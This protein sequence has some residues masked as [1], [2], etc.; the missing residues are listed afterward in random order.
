MTGL[1]TAE[2]NVMSPSEK[3]KKVRE[4]IDVGASPED[5]KKIGRGA[6]VESVDRATKAQSEF[7]YEGFFDYDLDAPIARKGK[8][9]GMPKELAEKES[10]QH[11]MS[12]SNPSLDKVREI[13]SDLQKA[14][15][16]TEIEEE[17]T[18]LAELNND[19]IQDVHVQAVA[20]GRATAE[21]AQDSLAGTPVQTADDIS[22]FE[23]FYAMNLTRAMA[24]TEAAEADQDQKLAELIQDDFT[25]DVAIAQRVA[26]YQGALSTSFLELA[27]GAILDVIPLVTQISMV[28]AINSVLGESV[29]SAGDLFRGQ[30]TKNIR[31]KL[32]EMPPD[33]RYLV[34][35]DIME[36]IQESSGFLSMADYQRQQV[37]LSLFNPEYGL[38][39]ESIDNAISILD[40]LSL[41]WTARALWTSTKVGFKPGS[42]LDTLNM[43]NPDAAAKAA[44]AGIKTDAGDVLQMTPEEIIETAVLPSPFGKDFYN[45][46]ADITKYLDEADDIVDNIEARTLSNPLALLPE[47]QDLASKVIRKQLQ[48]IN[49]NG[50]YDSNIAVKSTENSVQFT[51]NY[52]YRTAE[53]VVIPFGTRKEALD[54][55]LRQFP[56]AKGIKIF[57]VTKTKG[58]RPVPKNKFE[59]T[60]KGQYIYEVQGEKSAVDIQVGANKLF[61]NDGD[62]VRS[63]TMK[64]WFFDPA[65]RF[66]KWISQGYDQAGDWGKGI[67]TE[68]ATLAK[69]FESLKTAKQRH[70]VRML[71]DYAKD[72]SWDTLRLVSEAGDDMDVV[73]GFLSLRKSFD[74]LYT[75]ENREFRKSLRD[76]GGKYLFIDDFQ[77]VAF[78]KSP[79]AMLREI[80]LG[81]LTEVYDPRTGKNINLNAKELQKL[82]DN[83]YS[84]H[85][86]LEPHGKL[87]SKTEYVVA[88]A[89]DIAELPSHVLKKIDGYIPRYYKDTYFVRATVRGVVNGVRQN[90][91]DEV[92]SALPNRADALKKIDDLKKENR[93]KDMDFEVVHDRS[94]NPQERASMNVQDSVLLQ[95]MFYHKRGTHLQGIDGLSEVSDPIEALI[96]NIDSTARSV[97]HSDLNR[98]MKDRWVNTFGKKYGLV[99]PAKG[100]PMTKEEIGATRSGVDKQKENAIELWE[101]IRASEGM[102]TKDQELWKNSWVKFADWIQGNDMSGTLLGTVKKPLAQM[103][104]WL[105]NNSVNKMLRTLAFQHLIGLNPFRQF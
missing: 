42:N 99:D 27:G 12:Q 105:S 39:D 10:F 26:D 9:S 58:L 4:A 46:P 51:A 61:L 68:L 80:D 93:Y 41:G 53:G 62:V 18:A 28:S 38:L 55:A 72:P 90:N 37:L 40:A 11:A 75:L 5:I 45:Y 32:E 15:F 31:K 78:P 57:S 14:G 95:R 49:N 77:G 85:K 52:G 100:F 23:R 50:L 29:E 48:T 101:H 71:Q 25:A 97:S 3:D 102:M 47:E 44:A 16:N 36:A 19:T 43:A 73:K 2:L 34:S 7:S 30:Y 86:L 33:L 54:N 70:V 63:G 20:N 87:R 88:K 82:V 66:A 13:S 24:P 59:D 8:E 89:D 94:L 21:E 104:V 60:R 67:A 74:A 6:Y 92:L 79:E 65:S 76:Q 103:A 22:T 81:R 69:P 91:I 17:K 84:F 96:K 35:V 98:S 56:D 64:K 1:T 83:N